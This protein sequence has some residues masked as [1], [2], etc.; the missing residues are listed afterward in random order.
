MYK[1]NISIFKELGNLSNWNIKKYIISIVIYIQIL[2]SIGTCMLLY[3]DNPVLDGNLK[4]VD[5]GYII[6]NDRL[7]LLSENKTEP[8]FNPTNKGTVSS[9][10]TNIQL[11]QLNESIEFV[12]WSLDDIFISVDY[13]LEKNI[14]KFYPLILHFGNNFDN[15]ISKN[16]ISTERTIVFDSVEGIALSNNDTFLF[17]GNRKTTNEI[18]DMRIED[19][20]DYVLYFIINNPPK[21]GHFIVSLKN[22]VKDEDAE[23]QFYRYSNLFKNPPTSSIGPVEYAP[24]LIKAS[25]KSTDTKIET[26]F[27]KS[28]VFIREGEK[29]EFEIKFSSNKPVYI[30]A[31]IETRL[32]QEIIDNKNFCSYFDNDYIYKSSITAPDIN[33]MPWEK[34]SKLKTELT[35]FYGSNGEGRNSFQTISVSNY[36]IRLT[37]LFYLIGITLTLGLI[38]GNY[39][40]NINDYPFLFLLVVIPTIFI[41]VSLFLT[42]SILY[43]S[44]KINLQEPS[45]NLLV[46]ISV[47]IGFLILFSMFLYQFCNSISSLN[48]FLSIKNVV[49][50]ISSIPIFYINKIW[51][52]APVIL[53]TFEAISNISLIISY[54]QNFI[55]K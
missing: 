10:Q 32:G 28:P 6:D 34:E 45:F 4:K 20:N 17:I 5:V 40:K 44:G 53:I 48:D 24:F 11:D 42:D 50:L 16:G 52:L 1:S 27:I 41:M 31:Q 38:Y 47:S 21:K 26:R 22:L 49:L 8:I 46:E 12:I 19:G 25:K 3:N 9:F 23:S 2:S 14:D 51:L 30:Q 7:F 36:F 13:E 37:Y 29:S 18:F 33:S 39:L 15:I 35:Y 43:Y 55:K 54:I